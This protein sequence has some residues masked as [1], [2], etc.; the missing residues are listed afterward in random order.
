MTNEKEILIVDDSEFMRILIKRVL[1]NAGFKNIIKTSSGDE[2]KKLLKTEKPNLV[3]LD[4]NMPN[5]SGFDVLK[6]VNEEKLKIK[7]IIVSSIA[8]QYTIDEA[9]KLGAVG[10]IKKPFDEEE[11]IKLVNENLGE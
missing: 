7:C 3:L 2:A 11:L 1:N 6:F 8:Q 5:S 4:L 9:Y 10:Y